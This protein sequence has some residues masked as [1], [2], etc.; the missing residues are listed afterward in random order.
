[1]NDKDTNRV[2]AIMDEINTV[3]RQS[4]HLEKIHPWIM[5]WGRRQGFDVKTDSA[6]NILITVPATPGYEKSPTIVLQGHMDMVCEKRSDVEH[7]FRKDPVISWRDGD[8]LRAKGTSLG[9]DN[10]IALALFFDLATDP[11]AEHPKLEILVTADEET[12]LVGAQNMEAGF[13][14]GT[15][16]MNLDSEDEGVFT[17]GCAGG[18][19]T[20]LN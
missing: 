1:M 20:N 10:A 4:N 9:A 5:D 11:E 19:D 18:M 6:Q 15:V 12:G 8:W 2:L 7:D 13:L 3:P 17:I 16:L 14:T